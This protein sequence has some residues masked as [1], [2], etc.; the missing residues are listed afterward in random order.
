MA[1]LITMCP[2]WGRS[3]RWR[4]WRR[5]TSRTKPSAVCWGTLTCS[6]L[7]TASAA[8][9]HPTSENI[10][11]RGKSKKFPRCCLQYNTRAN[12]SFVVCC[13][14]IF[15]GSVSTKCRFMFTSENLAK[16]IFIILAYLACK[17]FYTFGTNLWVISTN[18]HLYVL[19]SSGFC[20]WLYWVVL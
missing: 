16:A 10:S 19:L 11:T 2:C 6:F 5:S 1:S 3:S 15:V 8:C 14:L 13:V 17:F 20:V 9:C 7:M 18:L 12:R 4:S